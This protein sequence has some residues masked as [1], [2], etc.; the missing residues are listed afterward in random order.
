MKAWLWRELPPYVLA[1]L[2]GAAAAVWLHH[3]LP[4]WPVYAA[5]ALVLCFGL[6]WSEIRGQSR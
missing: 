1:A 3:G 6:W 2:L 4:T 5:A